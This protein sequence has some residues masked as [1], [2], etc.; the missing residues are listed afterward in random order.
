MSITSGPVLLDQNQIEL[1]KL[2]SCKCFGTQQRYLI[3]AL[4]KEHSHTSGNI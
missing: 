1:K 2:L 4:K 3:I